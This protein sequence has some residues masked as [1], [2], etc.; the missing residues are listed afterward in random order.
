MFVKAPVKDNQK[1]QIKKKI[2]V[3]VHPTLT[4]VSEQL[5]KIAGSLGSTRKLVGT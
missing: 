1:N 5:I 3:S 2:V 4:R